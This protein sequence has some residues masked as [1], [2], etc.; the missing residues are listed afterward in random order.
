MKKTVVSLLC[1]VVFLFVSC[2][3]EGSSGN[4]NGGSRSAVENSIVDL[5]SCISSENT[6]TRQVSNE[7][8]ND[9]RDVYEPIRGTMGVINAWAEIATEIV[10]TFETEILPSAESGDWTN[11]SMDDSD[12]IY[13]IVWG[14]ST[15][16]TEYDTHAE[17]F[18]RDSTDSQVKGIDVVMT[19]TGDTAKGRI[20]FDTTAMPD[21]DGTFP[22]E[23]PQLTII[24]DGTSYPKTMSFKAVNIPEENDE[25]SPTSIYGDVWLTE[26]NVLQLAA[27]YYYP[28]FILDDEEPSNP[29]ERTNTFIVVGYNEEGKD[30]DTNSNKAVLKLAFPKVDDYPDIDSD[31][32]EIFDTSSIGTIYKDYF[33]AKLK[34]MWEDKEDES[35]LL[36][37]TI[38]VD[39]LV[40]NIS[41]MTDNQVEQVIDWY[42]EDSP[43]N[44]V[45]D[46]IYVTKLVNPAYFEADGFSGT[47]NGTDG[48]LS[49]EPT[50]AKDS[51]DLDI[52]A[53]DD[54]IIAPAAVKALEFNENDFIVR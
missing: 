50:W 11:D 30:D 9:V 21:D 1:T 32:S 14:P 23:S 47:Y 27:S 26:D 15:D 18:W 22:A 39:P 5:P 3:D 38:G 49:A 24:F 8:L 19:I 51:D 42:T 12:D 54:K 17:I 7:I 28:E 29:D 40:T 4:S 45:A 44:D 53:M 2:A 37:Q 48:T 20:T 43:D 33:Y 25:N 31:T 34:T 52:S 10:K 16:E 35:L 13:R 6:Q 46:L 36:F 41:N